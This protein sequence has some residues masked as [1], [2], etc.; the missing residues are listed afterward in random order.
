[1]DEVA[2][3]LFH[4]VKIQQLFSQ[5]LIHKLPIKMDITNGMLL[6]EHT[7]FKLKHLDIMRQIALL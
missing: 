2:G 3:R 5:T 1:M 7:V 4:R 6:K